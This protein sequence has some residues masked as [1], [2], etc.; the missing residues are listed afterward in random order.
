MMK[1]T[2]SHYVH[3]L[4]TK[5]VVMLCLIACT[6]PVV[7]AR[8]HA[9]LV[10]VSKYP[11]LTLSS[12]LEGSA[13]DVVLMKQVLQEKGFATRHIQVLSEKSVLPTR[14]NILGA[15]KRLTRQV[16]AGDFVFLYFAGH[17]SQQPI[18]SSA[19]HHEPDGLDEIFLP[20]DIGLWN[21]QLGT[22]KNVIVDNELT[23]YLTALRRKGVFIWIVF[24]S[25]HSGTMTRAIPKKDIRERRVSPR[26]LGIPSNR[27]NR[28]PPHRGVLAE[29]TR[30][31]SSSSRGS[32]GY[33]AFYAAQ[34]TETTP[35]LPLPMNHWVQ[36]PHGLFTY[37]L[38]EVLS[39]NESLSYRQLGE[40]ILQRYAAQS[41]RSSTPLFEGTDLD[42]PIFGSHAHGKSPLLQWQIQRKWNRLKI[43]AGQIH[44]LAQGSLLAILSN[45][46]ATHVLG[47]A[48]I[49]RSRIFDS[50]IKSISYGGKP[51]L[52]I[53]RLSKNAYLRLVEP[54][55][56]LTLRIALLPQLKR[57]SNASESK[58]RQVL[59]KIIA[60]KR[61]FGVDLKWVSAN[62]EADLHLLLKDDQLWFLPPTAELIEKGLHK[63]HS[64]RINTIDLREKLVNRFQ[65]IANVLSLLRIFQQIPRSWQFARQISMSATIE[66]AGKRSPFNADKIPRLYKGDFLRLDVTNRSHSAV[67]VTILFLDSEYGIT[68]MYPTEANE[69]NRIE[70]G[71]NGLLKFELFADTTGIERLVVIAVEAQPKTMMKNFSFLAQPKLPR[72]RGNKAPNLYNLFLDAGLSGKQ[73]SSTR[74]VGRMRRHFNRSLIKV[75]SWYMETEP[76]R[77]TRGR[78]RKRQR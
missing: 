41:R 56:S 43:A 66:H 36:R 14:R 11:N 20:R 34:T 50:D 22:V 37:T 48:K 2:L 52:A 78:V 33:V 65:S 6:F 9:L 49:T 76:K 54:K 26:A 39:Q 64:I 60:S 74:G 44:G 75:F 73:V 35:E 63:T 8:K 59:K 4:M 32:A 29:S 28:L 40:L 18:S 24:D 17:G 3:P 42:A 45:A 71:G 67:D 68:T 27:L 21:D 1:K 72:T 23:P 70:A 47:Y 15:L 31:D 10:G 30:R 69:V 58:M 19:Q 5:T 62:E 7:A 13:N 25:C 12:Q 51:A 61:K 38:A 46:T 57:R 55:V 16:R 53:K 77:M